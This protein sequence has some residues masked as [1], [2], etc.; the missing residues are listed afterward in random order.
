MRRLLACLSLLLPAGALGAAA[1]A[2][3][4]APGD[5]VI[6]EVM[7]DP[8]SPQSSSNEWVELYN[9]SAQA[10]DLSTLS[11]TDGT[12]APVPVTGTSTPLAPGG[13]AVLVRAAADFQAAYPGV[14]FVT[15]ASFPALNNTGDTPQILVGSTVIDAVPY[16][17][18]WG[19]VDRS[20]ERRDP[21]GPSDAASN[22][23]STTDASAG[24]PGRQNSL[25][26]V[27][28]APPELLGAAALDATTVEVSFSEPVVAEAGDYSVSDGVGP[29]A[30]ATAVAGD[31][32]RVRLSFTTPLAGPRTFTLTVSNVSDLAGNVLASDTAPF[33]FGAFDP[34]GARD[35]VVNEIMYDPPSPQPST[36]EWVEI[37]NRTP[38]RTFDL[39][40]LRL[41]VGDD[42]LAVTGAP[43]SLAPG[44]FAVLVNDGPQFQAAYPGV[45]FVV[46]PGFPSL[47]N[48]GDVVAVLA[49]ATVVDRVPYQ[50]SWGGADRSLERRDPAG[51]SA[52][53][54]NWGS[55]TDPDAG[56]PGA[57]NSLF[58][59]DTNGPTIVD[60]D[61]SIRAD[62]LTVTFDQPLDPASVTPGAFALTGASAPQVVGAVYDDSG[63]DALVRLALAAPLAP[64]TY[65]LAA[66]GVRDVNG[67]AGT[68]PAFTF[69]ANPDRTPP[70]IDGAV[71]LDA[72]TVE[73]TFSE[74]VTATAASPANYTVS[75][76][77]GQPSAVAFPVDGDLT[78]ARLTFATPLQERTLYTLT[79]T[80]VEDAAGNTAAGATATLFF[81]EADEPQPGD[82]VVNE[83][84]F[85]PAGSSSGEYVELFNTS[86]RTFD[87]R[88]IGLTD[89]DPAEADPIANAPV[90]VAPGAF[91]VIVADR[92]S[93]AVRFPG[94][95]AVEAFGFP[96]LN[97]S[98]DGV[99]VTYQ[100]EVIDSVR[101]DPDWH[102]IE[103]D[104]ATGVALERRDPDGPA[105][106]RLNWSSSLD[107]SGGTPGRANSVTTTPGEPP[108]DTGVAASASP[109]DPDAGEAT[110]LLYTLATDAA[111]VRVRIFDGAGRQVRT[112]ED[113]RLS[114]RTGQIPWDGRGDDGRALRI[115]IYVV[116]LEA[117]DVEGGTN[118]AHRTA[119]V[120]GRRF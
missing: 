17:T 44:A 39:S 33:F 10:V 75:G 8:P 85:D 67:A 63:G 69:E 12:A 112:I 97:N 29:P 65:T 60:V 1:H 83:I 55:T 119:V 56:T 5:V 68:G 41:V 4:P 89:G 86:D 28:T 38:D 49:G 95:P 110:A 13:Y 58:A 37:L 98:G 71:V 103:L 64:G 31:A 24:T 120:L 73:V 7:Y 2:Q 47:L 53:A 61:V 3:A 84:M 104:D 27:D 52:F 16:V 51:P 54:S 48:G 109:F 59:P 46:V 90:I 74:A 6:N 99:L 93:F 108:A 78:R 22:F 35:V 62:S 21:D 70:V 36:N 34:P 102:R 105:S 100:G 107:P 88:D 42:T 115:G 72:T 30:S 117:V 66:P 20:L 40:A 50:P 87:L 43:T 82:L 26:I 80:G 76:G 19:G 57:Q 32:T 77:I 94:V 14:A 81:G 45:P 111:L 116:L 118:E 9:R 92:D 114:G 79:V 15:V 23:G 11:F 91:V 25:F 106:S 18:S 101:Y 113:G 96:S